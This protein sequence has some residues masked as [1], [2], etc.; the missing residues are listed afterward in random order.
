[1]T[2]LKLDIK[3][4]GEKIQLLQK[5]LTQKEANNEKVQESL[6]NMAQEKQQLL[7]RYS[8]GFVHLS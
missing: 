6:S 8:V 4:K 1:M 5:Q 7:E 3:L 2:Q